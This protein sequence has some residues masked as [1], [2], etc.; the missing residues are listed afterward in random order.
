MNNQK[1]KIAVIQFKVVINAEK[2]NLRK[3]IDN[4]KIAA[5]DGAKLIC[6]PEA[7]KTSMNLTNIER[8]AETIPGTTSDILCNLSKE[9]GVYICAGILEKD[10]SKNYSSMIFIDDKGDLLH[11][12]RRRSIYDLEKRYLSCGEPVPVFDTPIGRIGLI[13][14]YDLFYP[15][16]CEY[17][18]RQN[19][20]IIICP[21]LLPDNFQYVSQTLV[22]A[23]A[24][25]N[26]CAFI[27][28]SGL[29]VN[30]FANL[31][32]M[33]E[34]TIVVDPSYLERIMFDYM[35]GDEILA[36]ASTDEEVIYGILDRS[37]LTSYIKMNTL[38]LDKYQ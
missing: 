36:K 38:Y 19:V 4:I 5:K 37:D 23:R 29:G 22:S 35:E 11:K 34:S 21:A 24:I 30:Q 27:Y 32:Y 28:A 26:A 14:G 7:F 6:L 31:N 20:E 12:Y 2:R 3:A 33:G 13:G 17:L 25:E 18:F 8:T 9:L 16:V 10:A 15:S 1:L